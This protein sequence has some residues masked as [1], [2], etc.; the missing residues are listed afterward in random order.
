MSSMFYKYLGYVF[1][2]VSLMILA[3]LFS[4]SD[5]GAIA[6]LLVI[7]TFLI[8]VI[9]GG[10]SPSVVALKTVNSK[11]LGAAVVGL[12]GVGL[13]A[14]LSLYFL[15]DLIAEF[16][17]ND[18]IRQITY[19]TC[20]SLVF[21]A[22]NVIPA[23]IL[24]REQKFKLI[25]LVVF[26]S[27]VSG[28]VVA[29]YLTEVIDPLMA[30][31]SK[32]PVFIFSN[33]ILNFFC[34]RYTSVGYPI[35]NLKFS[36]LAPIYN[37]A[38]YQFGFNFLNY[39]SRNID[40]VLVAKVFGAQSLGIYDQA[41][42]IM[43]YPIML[44]SAAMTPA[45]IPTLR[46]FS[47]NPFELERIHMRF[48]LTLLCLA[49]P[50]SIVIQMFAP[51]IVEILLGKQWEMVV[52]LIE[53]LAVSIPAQV[54]LGTSGSFF[55]LTGAMPMFLRNGVYTSIT[56]VSAILIGI[57]LRSLQDL[58]IMIVVAYTLVF[59]QTYYLMYKHIFRKDLFF[60]RSQIS[61]VLVFTA[62]SLYFQDIIL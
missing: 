52:P 9:E 12:F 26:V 35:P 32:A 61:I 45:I 58:T 47:D 37:M 38:K 59:I 4:P 56:V 53:M 41:Y 29:I 40:N 46:E 50:F 17:Q 23:S 39:F 27:E 48:S 42:R 19:L 24:L 55:Q 18:Q 28:T 57:Y 14:A 54:L 30:L 21:G 36:N 15:K 2:I 49:I 44:L 60:F 16:F 31:A 25:A 51:E 22:L 13:V 6:S 62:I 3:R 33:V 43:R 8:L 7:Y 11:T 1:S 20:C 10:V 34:C 5:F